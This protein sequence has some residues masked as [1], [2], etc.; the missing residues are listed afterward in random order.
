[1]SFFDTTPLGRIINRFSK[2]VDT[3]DNLLSDS[4]RMFLMTFTMIFAT[5]ILIIAFFYWFALAL[6]PLICGFLVAAMFYRATGTASAQTN[7]AREVK[8]LDSILRSHVYAQF[9]E[10]L[11]G[12]TTVRA[13]GKQAE[14]AKINEDY[15]DVMNRAYFMTIIDQRWL[16]IR[17]DFVGDILIF[18]VA[19]LVV[20][21]RFSVS[22]SIAGLVLAYCVQVVAMMGW[23]VRQ[24]AEVEN[25]MNATE[26]VHHYATA[27]ETEAPLDLP[28]RKPRESW[29]EKGEVVLK[30]V[31]LKYREG[32]PAVL[33][34][35]SLDIKGGERVGIGM[36]PLTVLM[37]V[38]RTGAGKSSIMVA[39]FRIVELSGGSIH[40]DGVDISQ[41]GL[42]D[43]RSAL[44]IIPQDPVLFQGTIRSNLDP[45]NQHDDNHLWESLRRAHLVEGDYHAPV[46][47]H[48]ND[49]SVSR[50]HLDQSVDDEGLNFSLGQRQLLAMA[51]ALV[52]KARI[53]IMDEATSS[54]DFETDSKIQT[55]IKREFNGATLLVLSSPG[56][57]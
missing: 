32:L 25:N 11:T 13:Y 2:D 1:M 28:D 48:E 39:L 42:H 14:F 20:T 19:I 4:Y 5:F 7:I 12:L 38:G 47:G 31:V 6:G 27:I 9:G 50:F 43:L 55:T 10:T 56:S 30:D 51:R 21:S 26:R 35:L 8:R 33:K 15:L 44:A 49:Q 29:P 16:G 46:V 36:F 24:F 54:V 37:I 17:L 22:P 3:M 52:R 23:M 57:R 41:I 40:I 18:V 53:I 45:F 34:N